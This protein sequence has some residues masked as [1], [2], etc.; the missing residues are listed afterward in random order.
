[1]HAISSNCSVVFTTLQLY[2]QRCR[3]HSLFKDNRPR[4]VATKS[5]N[6]K[7]C[8]FISKDAVFETRKIGDHQWHSLYAPT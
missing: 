6:G 2:T 3:I 8:V 4:K 5:M 7:G 1:M